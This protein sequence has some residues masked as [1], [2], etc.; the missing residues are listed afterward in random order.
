MWGGRHREHPS[1]HMVRRG[2]TLLTLGMMGTRAEYACPDGFERLGE[3]CYAFAS[4]PST[5]TAAAVVCEEYG[6]SLACP[7]TLAEAEMLGR[8]AT[9]RGQDFWISLTDV[10]QENHFVLPCTGKVPQ[11]DVPW[12]PG[13]PNDSGGGYF[14][15]CVRI[16]GHAGAH[17]VHDDAQP[18]DAARAGK[19]ADFRCDAVEAPEH[20]PIGFI[21]E[22]NPEKQS[23]WWEDDDDDDDDDASDHNPAA[24]FFAVVGCLGCAASAALNVVL[25]RRLHG[26]GGRSRTGVSSTTFPDVVDPSSAYRAPLQEAGVPSSSSTA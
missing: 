17:N 9:S 16:M 15:D 11:Y 14:G 10:M 21:C 3:S 2:V 1:I 8:A 13:E 5:K 20:A 7:T 26:S 19:W 6:A 18:G 12:G 25:W 22:I 4:G 23:E 24:I